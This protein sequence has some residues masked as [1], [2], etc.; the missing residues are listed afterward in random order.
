MGWPLLAGIVLLTA[1][2]F[3]TL[4]EV[5]AQPRASI[6][7]LLELE[8]PEDWLEPFLRALFDLLRHSVLNVVE[9]RVSFRDPG[10]ADAKLLEGLSRRYP[11]LCFQGEISEPPRL[12]AG[13]R[14]LWFLDMKKS[15]P[16][17]VL[18]LFKQVLPEA[19]LM[20]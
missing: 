16:L 11:A 14:L 4:S 3:W 7:L 19:A 13:A 17:E 1:W 12:L 20:A 8:H 15:H 5:N 18:A 2:V 6:I 9:V 10:L